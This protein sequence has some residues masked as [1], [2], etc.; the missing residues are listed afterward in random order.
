MTFPPLKPSFKLWP[1]TITF[2]LSALR[3][4]LK[5]YT[6][7]YAE[8]ST[9]LIYSLDMRSWPSMHY[10]VAYGSVR[11]ERLEK[12]RGLLPIDAVVVHVVELN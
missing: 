4:A 9:M 3:T 12:S 8:C 11:R 6:E 10:I 1:H 5:A 7:S 2:L